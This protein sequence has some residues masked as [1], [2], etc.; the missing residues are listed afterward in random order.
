MR[1]ARAA[2]GQSPLKLGT[3]RWLARLAAAFGLSVGMMGSSFSAT[4]RKPRATR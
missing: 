2:M 4:W 3:A 1:G